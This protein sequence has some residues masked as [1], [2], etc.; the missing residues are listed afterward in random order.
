MSVNS[1]CLQSYSDFT[2]TLLNF[3]IFYKILENEL[4]K[5]QYHDEYICTVFVIIIEIV[6]T[7]T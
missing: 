5:Y 6:Q 3:K 7:M 2:F 4:K 1:K